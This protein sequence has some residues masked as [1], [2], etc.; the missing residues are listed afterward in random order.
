MFLVEEATEVAPAEVDR[1]VS[2]ARQLGLQVP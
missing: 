1:L 2:R